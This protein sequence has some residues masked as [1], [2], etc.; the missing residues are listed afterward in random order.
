MALPELVALVEETALATSRVDA[1]VGDEGGD[2]RRLL[3]SLRE[4]FERATRA[5]ESWNVDQDLCLEVGRV[6]LTIP[7]PTDDRADVAEGWEE[8]L[9]GFRELLFQLATAARGETAERVACLTRRFELFHHARRAE[10]R[11]REWMVVSGPPLDQLDGV[12]RRLRT[13]EGRES[14]GPLDVEALLQLWEALDASDQSLGEESADPRLEAAQRDPSHL[15]D[16][17]APDELVREL[18]EE[19]ATL[20]MYHARATE[21]RALGSLAI[22]GEMWLHDPAAAWNATESVIRR[23]RALRVPTVEP[24][25]ERS[26]Q[27]ALDDCE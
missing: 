8:L 20:R 7:R 27:R 14:F 17:I 1:L 2:E 6:T 5:C 19:L 10:A 23:L 3:E 4:R 24:P 9:R 26:V 15:A 21:L 22:S 18:L 16:L 25:S 11:A 13:F 12:E